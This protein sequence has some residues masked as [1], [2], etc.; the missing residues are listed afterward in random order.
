MNKNGKKFIEKAIKKHGDNIDF[1]KVEYENSKRK[2]CLICHKK[3]DNGNEHGEYWQTPAACVRGDKCPKC[4]NEKRGKSLTKSDFIKRERLTHG[5]KYIVDKILYKNSTTKICVICPEHGEFW[6]L[7]SAHL[8]GQGCPK[9]VGRQLSTEDIISKFRIIHGNSYN[10]EKSIYSGAKAK[11]EIICHIHG[12]FFQTP[13]KHLSGQGCP[14]CGNARKNKERTLTFDDIVVRANKIHGNKYKYIKTDVS[15]LHN[16]LHIVCPKHGE[17][18]QLAYDHLKGHGCSKCGFNLSNAENEIFDFI[19]SLGITDIIRN[20][21]STIYP[22]ELDLYIPTLKLGIEYNG[23]KW[24]SDEFKTNNNYHLNKTERCDKIGIQLIH[25]FEDEYVFSKN[26]VLNR[27]EYII[28]QIIGK[29]AIYGDDYYVRLI[30]ESNAKCFIDT[31]SLES[32]SRGE[33]YLG[34]YR[35]DNLVGVMIFSKIDNDKNIW[36]IN[37]IASN[38]MDYHN[39]I[40]NELFSF[41]IREYDFDKIITYADRRWASDGRNNIFKALGF[42]FNGYTEPNYS[43]IID[44][45]RISENKLDTIA[46]SHRIYDCGNIIYTY[47]NKRAP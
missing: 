10:Y 28:N 3:D 14:K 32:F 36:M 22:Y 16:K 31:N 17:F 37:Q 20:N 19:K 23:L 47:K 43:Y 24:H 44:N 13:Q 21:R 6:Q 39:H 5:D 18:E 26:A 2:V 15:N 27:L 33:I 7:P 11:L 34:C 30:D 46:N 29:E 12:S 41:F 4:G 25:I 9:C 35:E 8:N 38:K 42:H 1:S 40:I 45:K